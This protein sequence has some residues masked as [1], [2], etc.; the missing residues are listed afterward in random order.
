MTTITTTLTS[1]EFPL[2][3]ESDAFGELRSS[4][5]ILHSPETQQVRMAEDGYLLLRGY[6]DKEVVNSARRE[7]LTKLA[8]VGEIDAG[9]PLDEAI[10]TGAATW[11][12]EFVRDLRTGPAI[13][14]LCHE[15]RIMEF[16]GRFLG[17]RARSFD[18]IWVRRVTPGGATGCH[19]DVVYMGRGSSRLYTA[20]IPVGDVTFDLGPLAILEKSHTLEELK[21]TYGTL[22]DTGRR[23]RPQQQSLPRR[24]VQQESR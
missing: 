24:L 2:N 16:F 23:P 15:G 19:Y 8:A 11:T 12:P 14:S 1:H 6:L 7:L 22:W 18:H 17:E 10:F 3:T 13:R 5:T 20:W 9:R 4:N 21:S